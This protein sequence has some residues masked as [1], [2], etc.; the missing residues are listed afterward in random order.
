MKKSW[1]SEKDVHSF[2]VAGDTGVEAR[3]SS[4]NVA[5]YSFQ[6]ECKGLGKE[7]SKPAVQVPDLYCM[8]VVL[9]ESFEE[10]KT[11]IWNWAHLFLTWAQ[12]RGGQETEGC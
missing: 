3:R 4:E 7:V 11:R 2:E 5:V 12:F 8:V 1:T 10:P 6:T 9:T